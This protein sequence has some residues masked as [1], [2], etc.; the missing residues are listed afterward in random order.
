MCGM[1]MRQA[2]AIGRARTRA[3]RERRHLNGDA[4]ATFSKGKYMVLLGS[5]SGCVTTSPAKDNLTAEIY[6]R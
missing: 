4:G 6:E 3:E 2:R 1:F 5:V